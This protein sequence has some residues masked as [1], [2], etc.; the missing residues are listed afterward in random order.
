L[1]LWV[2]PD[3]RSNEQSAPLAAATPSGLPHARAACLAGCACYRWRG[4]IT[5][6]RVPELFVFSTIQPIVFVLMFRCVSG[7]AIRIPGPDS[8]DLKRRQFPLSRLTRLL[9]WTR[10]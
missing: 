2:F 9:G 10:G 6:R 3:S 7:G 8:V 1:R 4:V 5:Y